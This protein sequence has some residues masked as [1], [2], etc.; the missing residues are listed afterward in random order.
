MT[1]LIRWNP[2]RN[3][4]NLF[5]E[6]D[7]MVNDMMEWSAPTVPARWGLPLD[8]AETEDAYTVTAS[9]PGLNPD[10]IEV[11]LEENVLTIRGENQSEETTEEGTRYHLRERRFG[12]FSRSL[13]FPVL[14]AGEQIEANYVNGVLTLTVPKAEEVKP[15]RIAVKVA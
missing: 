3:R 14:V 9:I 10:D 11:T 5:N 4:T 6:F 2:T 1:T 8:V 15:K 12:S 7:R 13:R